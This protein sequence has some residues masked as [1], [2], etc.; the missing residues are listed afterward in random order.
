MAIYVG[1]PR[2]ASGLSWP[3]P[4]GI[5]TR[6]PLVLKLKKLPPESKWTGKVSYQDKE[7]DILEPAQVEQEIN[8]GECVP[9]PHLW[10]TLG[11]WDG[12]DGP[13]SPG[14]NAPGDPRRIHSAPGG[15]LPLPFCPVTAEC[16]GASLLLIPLAL[17]CH[18]WDQ[19]TS[20]SPCPTGDRDTGAHENTGLQAGSPRSSPGALGSSWGS[21]VLPTC[22]SLHQGPQQ[23]LAPL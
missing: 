21:E 15:F 22:P 9:Y 2:V 19:V 11:C 3:G 7:V 1:G 12:R 20:G 23:Q 14:P 17:G 4:A 16:P 8:K 5:V 10:A 13:S 18:G 6:C